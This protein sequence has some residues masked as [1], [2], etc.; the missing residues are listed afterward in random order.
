MSAF[1]QI[2]EDLRNAPLHPIAILRLE[3][4][5]LS[6]RYGLA[7]RPSERG[8]SVAAL[9]QTRPG[10]Q[11]MLLRHLDAPTVGTEVLV[12]ERSPHPRQDLDELLD[13]LDLDTSAVTWVLGDDQLRVQTN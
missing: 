6:Q 2:P 4:G 1:T 7:F 5:D 10:Q 9:L 8:D 12:S 3:Y 13:A 11:Y